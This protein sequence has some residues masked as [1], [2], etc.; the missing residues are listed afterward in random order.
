MGNGIG[1]TAGIKEGASLTLGV[2]RE[3]HP[4]ND[5]L[6]GLESVAWATERACRL[7]KKPREITVK[8]FMFACP[9]FCE[10]RE[11][12]KTAKLK[13]A[14]IDTVPTLIGITHVLESCGLNSPK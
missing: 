11:L 3:R 4:A 13:G 9:L 8:P 6:Q 2:N 12:N 14:N 1:R 10:F 5:S 7:Q